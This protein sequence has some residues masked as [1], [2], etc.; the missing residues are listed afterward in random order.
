MKTSSIATLTLAGIAL[1]GCS[2]FTP[3]SATSSASRGVEQVNS[4]LGSALQAPLEDLNLVRQEIPAVLNE[5]AAAPYRVQGMGT[6]TTI[7]AEIGRLDE[8]LGPD[9]DA[10]ASTEETDIGDKAA[11]A[12]ADATLDAVR[13]TVTDFIPARSWVRRLTGADRH[14]KEVQAAVRA[15]LQRRAFLKG[16]GQQ[17]NCAPPAAPAGY[18]RH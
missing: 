12:A 3:A 15:G 9:L 5:A 18:R 13:S 16:F 17:K 1:A 10:A 6:C 2:T 7:A 11:D 8:A 14:S 4:G